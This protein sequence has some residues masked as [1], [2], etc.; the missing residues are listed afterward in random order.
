MITEASSTSSCDPSKLKN[1]PS[2]SDAKLEEGEEFGDSDQLASEWTQDLTPV[3]ETLEV[4]TELQWSEPSFDF[5][6]PGTWPGNISDTQRCFIIK[7]RA[8]NEHT[9]HIPD[10]R[11]ST[12]DGRS[13]TKE[14]F[15]KLL[16]NGC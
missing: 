5:Q 12:R 8:E 7:M 16:P 15:F 6:D 14:W 3:P 2:E 11:K 4:L 13:L 10:L 1:S 9:E